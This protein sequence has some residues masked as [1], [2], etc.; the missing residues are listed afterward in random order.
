MKGNRKGQRAE[1]PVLETDDYR[2][3]DATSMTEEE[4][5]EAKKVSLAVFEGERVHEIVAFSIGAGLIVKVLSKQRISDGRIKVL[6]RLDK[7]DGRC[8]IVRCEEWTTHEKYNSLV[9]DM[10]KHFG[11]DC[12]TVIKGEELHIGL[13]HVINNLHRNQRH[14]TGRGPNAPDTPPRTAHRGY[15][16]D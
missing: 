9:N 2:M 10:K 16:G 7:P 12:A 5:E 11:G 6:I 3:W 13:S 4:Q 14:E 8:T 15:G 1:K